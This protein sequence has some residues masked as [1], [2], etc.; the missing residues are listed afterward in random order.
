MCAC[1]CARARRVAIETNSVPIRV[2]DAPTFVPRNEYRTIDAKVIIGVLVGLELVP[3]QHNVT[4][5]VDHSDAISANDVFAWLVPS[6]EEVER[7]WVAITQ[8]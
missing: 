5:A 6:W 1:G 4:L 3:P 8:H 7:A 2:Q